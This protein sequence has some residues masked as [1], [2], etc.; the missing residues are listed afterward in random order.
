M[1][2]ALVAIRDAAAGA[3]MR[4]WT[5]PSVGMARRSFQDECVRYGSDMNKHPEDFELFELGSFDEDS[6]KVE[7][8]DYPRSLARAI[9]YPGEQDATSK[10]KAGEQAA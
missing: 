1:K 10:Q 4:P 3:F 7:N 5:V 6:G 8:L 9:D 2:Y